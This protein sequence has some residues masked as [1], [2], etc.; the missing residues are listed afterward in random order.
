MVN[1]VKY[2]LE[3]IISGDNLSDEEISRIGKALADGAELNV[4]DDTVVGGVEMTKL[5]AEVT[6]TLDLLAEEETVEL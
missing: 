3:C 1:A 6:K 4:T 5:N 2:Q